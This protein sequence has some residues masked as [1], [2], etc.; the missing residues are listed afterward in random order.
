V[1]VNG[2]CSLRR[3]SAKEAKNGK[4]I[5]SAAGITHRFLE[6][7]RTFHHDNM[8]ADGSNFSKSPIFVLGTR[9]TVPNADIHVQEARVMVYR[10]PDIQLVLNPEARSPALIWER[11]EL[12]IQ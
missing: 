4:T 10:C 2:V 12:M 11:E 8:H 6:Y 1:T 9:A 5:A 3:W 7:P